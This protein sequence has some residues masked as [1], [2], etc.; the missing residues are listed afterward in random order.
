MRGSP[1]ASVGLSTDQGTAGKVGQSGGLA[2]AERYVDVLTPAG[3]EATQQCCLDRVCCVQAGRE[4][5]HGDTDLDRRSVTLAGD[6]HQTKLGLDHDVVARSLAV[7]PRLS[8][9]G[10]RSVDDAGVDLLERYVVQVVFGERSGQVV[11]DDNVA[12]G[13]DLLEDGLTLWRL[14][15]ESERLFVTIYLGKISHVW[16]GEVLQWATYSEKICTL[17]RALESAPF[18]V[19]RVR[20]TPRS[21]IV[22]AGRVFYLDNLGPV[23]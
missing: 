17:A 3:P 19:W 15:V 5:G 6:V 10:D 8:V 16:G 1:S 12:G 21:C 23:A 2:V 9:S 11:F 4:I 18:G 7:R 20:R 13:S 22:T 14:E